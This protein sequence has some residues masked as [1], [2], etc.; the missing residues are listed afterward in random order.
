MDNYANKEIKDEPASQSQ[1]QFFSDAFC[2]SL[3]NIYEDNNKSF[4]LFKIIDTGKYYALHFE[5]TAD[6][7]IPSFIKSKDLDS[8]KDVIPTQKKSLAEFHIQRVLKLYGQ[9]NII[10]VKPKNIRYW[11]T[12]IA[13]WD[14]DECY[15]DYVNARY[16][17]VER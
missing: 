13:L 16:G 6:M 14:S 15:S 9:N 2:K 4:K 7:I 1:I 3:N 11:S 5:Y 12:N 17:N 8:L 10:L